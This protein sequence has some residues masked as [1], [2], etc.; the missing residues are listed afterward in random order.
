MKQIS[1][2]GVGTQGP[3]EGRGVAARSASSS[4]ADSSWLWLPNTL[5]LS[6]FCGTPSI[7]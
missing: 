3:V 7:S 5:L 6:G 4:F 1:S 2:G